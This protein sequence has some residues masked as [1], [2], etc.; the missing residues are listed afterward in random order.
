LADS[1]PLEDASATHAPGGDGRPFDVF[2]S[3]NSQDKTVVERI[4]ERL[5]RERIEPWLDAW[6]LVPGAD[7]QRGLADRLAGC[8]SCARQGDVRA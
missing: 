4:A 1:V 3:H 7:W 5:K 8:R 2:L 6:H